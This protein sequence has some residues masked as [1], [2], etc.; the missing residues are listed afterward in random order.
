MEKTLF[1]DHPLR[2]LLITEIYVSDW[3]FFDGWSF[4]HLI[5]GFILGYFLARWFS[6]FKFY[7]LVFIILALYE[8]WE[9]L[10]D[11]LI[12]AKEIPLDIIWDL[13]VGMIAVAIAQVVY[14]RVQKSRGRA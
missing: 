2:Q 5:N 12:F 11:Q 13:I 4:V 9:N 1:A 7:V 14:S 6:G 10:T 8:V 3:I